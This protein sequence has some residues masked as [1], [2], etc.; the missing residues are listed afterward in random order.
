MQNNPFRTEVFSVRIKKLL[1][2]AAAF[3]CTVVF[4]TGQAFADDADD[5][6]DGMDEEWVNTVPPMS[7]WGLRGL[8]QTVSAEPGLG[9]LNFSLFWSL[10]TQDQDLS[11]GGQRPFGTYGPS[12]ESTVNTLMG[13]ISYGA[14]KY[15]DI[16]GCLPMYIL[17]DYRRT[18]VDFGIPSE[19]MGGAQ[20]VAPIPEEIPFRLAGQVKII[21]GLK[22]SYVGTRDENYDVTYGPD[23]LKEEEDEFPDEL[24]LT[25]AGYDYGDARKRDNIVLVL[26][27]AQTLPFVDLPRFA[28]KLHLNEGIDITPGITG[29]WL[30]LLAAGLEIDPTEYLT[31]GGEL[32][33]RTPINKDKDGANFSFTD[34]FW[35]TP[36]VMLRSPYYANGL[37]GVNF[38]VGMDIRLSSAKTPVNRV[39]NEETGRFEAVPI[40]DPN[41]TDY[42]VY[43]L[44]PWR[45]FADLAFSFDL[46]ASKRA[47]MARQAKANAAERAKLKK[48]AA[49]TAAQRDSIA[50]KAREDSLAQ[51]AA[52]AAKAEKARQDSIALA[53]EAAEREAK[54]RAEAESREAQLRAAAEGREAQ[55]IADAE[56][57]EAQLRAQAEQ[58]RIA[59]SIALAD[60]NKRLA[61][62]K[63]KRSAAEQQMLSTGMLVLDGVFFVT[64]KAEIQLNSR[65]YLTTLAKMLVRYPKLRME[66]GGHT[67]NTGSLQT[68]IELSQRRAEAVFMFL[69]NIEPSLSGMLSTKGY[70]P[71]VPKADNNT[72]A[73][74]EVNRRVEI[75]VLNPDVLREYNP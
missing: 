29:T 49:M 40:K 36:S 57:R 42:K 63:A 55:L 20:F 32:N 46:L 8:T 2:V 53:A 56:G 12:K 31:I 73:G 41:G 22:R 3:V 9:R 62:E 11:F 58:K 28:L 64:G 26:K 68:N 39:K 59:D 14:N 16:F 74:R 54:I 27:A 18:K 47:E 5:Y 67:D 72:A 4:A 30:F 13:K 23:Y 50:A 35:F 6:I 70:G 69:H 38:V 7:Y 19:L 45:V 33:W 25:Y 1:V 48:M 75:R 43:P 15:T 10:F 17:N 65:G 61:E 71:T 37:V 44:E 24:G 66:I 34:P 51:V 52:L 60:V 21:Y